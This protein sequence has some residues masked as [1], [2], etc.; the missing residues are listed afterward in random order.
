VD[1]I[2]AVADAPLPD[3]VQLES[4]VIFWPFLAAAALLLWIAG[5]GLMFL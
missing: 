2:Q 5:W 3:P 1:A 4:G